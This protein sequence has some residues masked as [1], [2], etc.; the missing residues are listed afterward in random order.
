LEVA[1]PFYLYLR[2]NC[3]SIFVTANLAKDFGIQGYR[4][5]NISMVLRI[6]SLFRETALRIRVG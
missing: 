4:L 5:E 2:S 1:H 6:T 3:C